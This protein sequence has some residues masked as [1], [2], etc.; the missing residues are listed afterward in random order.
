M[1]KKFLPIIVLLF[2]TALAWGGIKIFLVKKSLDVDPAAT[3]YQRPIRPKFDED[4]LDTL[5]VEQENLRV[6]PR[7]FRELKT[8]L[9]E[10]N[11]NQ[12]I[13]DTYDW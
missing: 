2:I 1:F 6:Q 7:V 4:V 5:R 9:I 8:Q 12:N 13:D 3:T 11:T 10:E